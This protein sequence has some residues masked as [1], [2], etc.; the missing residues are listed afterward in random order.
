MFWAEPTLIRSILIGQ[1]RTRSHVSIQYRNIAPEI[2]MYAIHA[3]FSGK[4]C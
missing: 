1:K 4:H 2:E 3:V